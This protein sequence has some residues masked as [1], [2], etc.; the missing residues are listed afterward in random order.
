MKYKN[1]FFRLDIRQEGTFLIVYPLISDGKALEINEILGYLD[2]HACTDYSKKDLKDMLD[3]MGQSS[4]ELKVSNVPIPAVNETAKVIISQDKMVAYVRFYP[5]STGGKLMTKKDILTELEPYKITYGV[6]DKIVDV[7]LMARQ[8]CLNIPIAKGKKPVPAQDTIIEYCFDTKPLSK[9]KMLEDGSVDFHELNLFTGVSKGQVLA[10]LTPHSMGE[11][12]CDIFGNE[13]LPNKPKIRALKYGRNITI[14]DDKTVITSNVDGNV[15]LTDDTVFVSDTYNVAADVDASTGDI[16]YDGSVMVPGNVRTGFT[17]R[18]KGDIQV[19]GV[20]EGATLIAGGNIVI[21][22]GV[23]GLSKGM[24]EAGGDICAQFFESANVV[25]KG[26]VIAGSILHSNVSSG[27]KIVVSGRKGFIVGGE[28]ICQSYVEVN[29]IGNRMETQTI[30]KVGV[31]PELYEEMKVLVS[32]AG[33]INV[34]IEELESYINVYKTKVNNGGKLSPENLKLIKE[35]NTKL[36]PLKEEYGKRNERLQ[37][38]KK[39][40]ELGKKGSIKVL[41]NTYRGVTIYIA[42]AIYIVKDKD[43]HSCYKIIDGDIRTTG[44]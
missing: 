11:P 40:L 19:N 21:K 43:T 39:E 8:Y 16:N 14:S 35:Y 37:E 20:V 10:K 23:Q 7:F 36:M 34:Q 18:A 9:P 2:L 3:G 5:P 17:I 13:I 24:L 4:F 1:S 22:R 28:I 38:I 6:S 31:N 15:T 41:G 12:G 29:S 42:N 25:A 44:F 27:G 26:D 32:E 30:V 33:E